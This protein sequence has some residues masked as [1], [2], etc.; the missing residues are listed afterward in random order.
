MEKPLVLVLNLNLH[1]KNICAS[2]EL[3]TIYKLEQQIHFE[4]RIIWKWMKVK[5]KVKRK[6]NLKL[7]QLLQG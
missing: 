4:K 2:A 5:H 1:F 6:M 3:P 7:E